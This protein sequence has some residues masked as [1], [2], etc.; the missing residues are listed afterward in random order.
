MTTD[1]VDAPAAGRGASAGRW[2]RWRVLVVASD[3]QVN[4]AGRYATIVV[5]DRHG[6]IETG[7]EVPMGIMVGDHGAA[8]ND[9]ADLDVPSVPA[10]LQLTGHWLP[11]TW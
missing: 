9:T 11:R 3:P 1:P 6:R 5:Y 10:C 7:D 8:L 4:V 2:R